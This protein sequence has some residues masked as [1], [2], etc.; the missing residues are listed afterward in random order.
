M[1][2]NRNLFNGRLHVLGNFD[3]T[4]QRWIASENASKQFGK[5][6]LDLAVDQVVD[7]KFIEPVS[8]FQLPC[9]RT[10]NDDLRVE[11][12]NYRMSHDP[13]ELVS[14]HRHE[15]FAREF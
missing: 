7:T 14:I 2:D 6:T 1:S 13:D 12:T 3:D 9:A 4:R 11:F 15:I 10:T 8:L 5:H